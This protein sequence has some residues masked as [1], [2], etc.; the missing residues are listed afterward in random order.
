[1]LRHAEIQ[2][3]KQPI[4]RWLSHALAPTLAK[5]TRYGLSLQAE[6]RICYAAR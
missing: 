3:S 4:I 1:M 2:S 5:M 6:K